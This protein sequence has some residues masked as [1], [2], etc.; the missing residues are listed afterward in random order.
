MVTQETPFNSGDISLLSLANVLLRRRVT[1]VGSMLAVAF[2]VGMFSLTSRRTHTSSATF[3]PQSTSSQS[4]LGGLAAQ[5]GFIPPGAEANQSPE[6]YA[7]LLKSRRILEGVV[8]TRYRTPTDSVGLLTTILKG[9][10]RTPAIRRE[11]AIKRLSQA[12][13]TTVS[14]NTGIVRL[15]VRMDDAVLAQRVT[16]RYLEL[17][18]E[19]NLMTRQSQAAAEREFSGNRVA[20]VKV[21]LKRAEDSLQNFLQHNRD[22]R[23]SPELTFRSERLT[24]DVTMHQQIYTALV[25]AYEQAKIEEVRD[26]PVIT[27]IETPQVPVRPDRRRTILKTILGLILGGM[28]GVGLAFWREFVDSTSGAEDTDLVEFARL[29]SSLLQ[30]VRH[31]LRA[32]KR[33]LARTKVPSL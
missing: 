9:S 6:F 23:S 4:S 24:R 11:N 2:V 13:S 25:Q 7:E 29:R 21:D 32:L 26:T 31:P 5:F 19:F 18:N 22:Y 3:V 1:V 15:A 30:D 16:A 28:F 20:E 17:V 27:I 12:T 10:G 8:D 14:R 33:G